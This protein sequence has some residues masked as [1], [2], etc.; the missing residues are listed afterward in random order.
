MD[1]KAIIQEEKNYSIKEIQEIADQVVGEV[2]NDDRLYD[3]QL[4]PFT[5][6][7]EE[8]V[9]DIRNYNL[10]QALVGGDIIEGK[11]R[12]NTDLTGKFS[13]KDFLAKSKEDRLKLI[14]EL[15]LYNMRN[16]YDKMYKEIDSIDQRNENEALECD[17]IISDFKILLQEI[18]S[19]C[20]QYRIFHL[21]IGSTPTESEVKYEG[22]FSGNYC[23][24]ENFLRADWDG[25]RA[26]VTKLKDEQKNK[27]IKK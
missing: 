13:I 19:D 4:E 6:L 27:K 26:I 16:L 1:E 11:E 14:Q 7:L 23:S 21:L 15:W 10:Y 12:I 24:V 5:R 22:D 17:S 2:E 8:L 18:F 20:K 25:K 3:K 9:P